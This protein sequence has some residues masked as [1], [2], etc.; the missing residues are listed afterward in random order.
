MDFATLEEAK[1]L[2]ALL[3]MKPNEDAMVVLYNFFASECRLKKNESEVRVGKIGNY[4]WDWEVA[5]T[6]KYPGKG[7]NW[8]GCPAVRKAVKR[9][10][11]IKDT[12]RKTS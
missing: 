9:R 1:T 2:V 11:R 6:E 12:S 3:K 8:K 5:V 10:S 4:L 7:E